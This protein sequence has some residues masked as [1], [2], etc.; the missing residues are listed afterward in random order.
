MN[1]NNKIK[2]IIAG[3][4][5]IALVGIPVLVSITQKRQELRSRATASTTL[6][7]TPTASASSPLQAKVGD[8]LVFDIMLDPGT[9]LPSVVKLEIQ[10]DPAKLQASPTSFLANLEAFPTTL[11][12][13]RLENGSLSVSLSTGSD[14][15]RAI[16]SITKVGTLTLTAL[17]P[18]GDIPTA[19][20]YGANTLA[21]SIAST[22]RANENIL[23]TAIPAYVQIPDLI[24]PTP[25]A[26]ASATFLSL[27]AYLHGIGGSGD[28]TNPNDSRLSNKSPQHL[29]KSATVY[30]FDNQNLLISSN[31]GSLTYAPANGNFIGN[32]NIGSNVPQGQYTIKIQTSAHLLRLVPGI[33]TIMP[34]QTNAIPA[35]S[36]IAGDVN[37]DNM[38]NILDYNM[39]INCYSDL[40]PAKACTDANKIL[41]DL[42][43]DNAVNQVDYNLFLREISVQGGD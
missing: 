11:E 31:S 41:T 16:Q 29:Q 36:L 6:Y 21:L 25:S 2:Y 12:G 17:S 28:N 8:S 33:Q 20:T 18:T 9:N 13:P 3:F 14:T 22:D 37:N 7:F 10:F 27:T 40:L 19:I 5:V 42:N 15:T 30:I 4:F 26:S 1:Y 34:Q 43:D 39:I 38:L 23:S 32:I 35:V 24:T